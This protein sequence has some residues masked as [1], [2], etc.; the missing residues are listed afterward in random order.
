MNRRILAAVQAAMAIAL[1]ASCVSAKQPETDKTPDDQLIARGVTAWN[2]KG[3]AAAQPF[4]SQIQD[5]AAKDRYSAYV[6]GYAAAA[7]SLDDARALGPEEDAAIS[8]AYEKAR[9]A[10]A[11]FPKE[12]RIP[13]ETKD[14]AIEVVEGRMRAGIDGNKLSA[15]RELAKGAAPVFGSSDAIVSMNAEIDAILAS[16][17]KEAAADEALQKARDRNDFDEK[18]A[19]FETAG[20]MFSGAEASLAEGARQ[21]GLSGTAGIAAQASRLKRKRQDAAIEKEKLLRERAYSFKDR[22]GEEFARAPEGNTTGTMSLEEL[23][24]HQES[25]KAAVDAD[26]AEMVAFGNR[27]PSVI[28]KEMLADVDAQKRELEGKIAQVNQEIRTAKDIASRGKTAMPIMIGLFNPVPGTSEES[29]KSRPATFRATGQ[30]GPEYWW[31]M[32]SIPK[33]TMNDLVITMKDDRAVRVFADN[34]KSGKL[35]GKNGLADLVNRGYKV[36]NSWPVLNAG[37]QLPTEKYFFEV[38]KGKTPEYQG[39]AVIYSSFVMRMR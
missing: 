28:D 20:G 38:A 5:V 33:K 39:E 13:Q 14:A 29:K 23:L 22:I 36:G 6:N 15:A 26:Y 11:A 31:G 1:L 32:V 3:P 8:G 4:W 12:L 9:K 34:T 25:V 16:R 17:A 7:K 21:N 24:K 37:S 2:D 27:Y 30:K 10:C 35:I 19:G 18:V